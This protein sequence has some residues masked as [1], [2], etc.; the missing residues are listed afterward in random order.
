MPFDYR[1]QKRMH[2]CDGKQ[3]V[4]KGGNEQMNLEKCLLGMQQRMCG[5]KEQGGGQAECG[6][7]AGQIPAGTPRLLRRLPSQ[8]TSTVSQAMAEMTCPTPSLIP[9]G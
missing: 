7:W 5:G 1:H 6:K 3:A 4:G 2:G 8:Y 9:S